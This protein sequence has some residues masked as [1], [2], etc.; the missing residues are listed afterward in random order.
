MLSTNTSTTW[1]TN[2]NNKLD[3]SFFIEEMRSNSFNIWQSYFIILLSITR[4]HLLNNSFPYT[5]GTIWQWQICNQFGH[6]ASEFNPREETYFTI[7]FY[8]LIRSRHTK[9]I[10][11]HRF[12]ISSLVFILFSIT[13]PL[14]FDSILISLRFVQLCM[15]DSWKNHSVSN[16][17]S[18]QYIQ[19]K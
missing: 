9:G 18:A 15:Y 16:Q 14:V 7:Y 6:L 11:L 19:H 2:K 13:L 8:L 17:G 12:P 3:I 4:P 5:F 1:W 10:S